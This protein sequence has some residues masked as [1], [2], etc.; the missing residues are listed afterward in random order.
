MR[1][2]KIPLGC[3][4][5]LMIV[6]TG[7]QAQPDF[8]CDDIVRSSFD[9]LRIPF[10]CGKP[11]DTV[12]LPIILDNDSTVTS[13]QFLIEFDTAWLIPVFIRDSSC[14]VADQTGCISWN[15]D[16]TYIDHVITGRM[17]ITD[18]TNGEFGLVIDTINQFTINLFQ[19][20]RNVMACNGVPEFLTLDSLPPGD[21]TIFYVKMAVKPTVPDKRLIAYDFFASNIFIVDDTVFPPDTTWFSGCNTSQMVVA[22]Y[23]GQTSTGKDSVENYQIYPNTELGYTFW[24][25][26]DVDCVP[27]PDPTVDLSANPATIQLG[28][29]SV[30]S[31]TSTNADS[32]VVR[33]VSNTRLADTDN[34]HTSGTITVAPTTAGVF[35]YTAIAYGQQDKTASDNATVT[36]SGGGGTGPVMSVN[37][38][39]SSYDQGTPISFTVTA[40][41]TTGSQI[42]VSASNLPSNAGFGNGGSVTGVSPLSGTFSW[43]PDFNQKGF[44]T[45][46]FTG[47]DAGGTTPLPVTFEVNELKFDRLF[48]TSRSGDRPV[49]GRPGKAGISFPIDLVTSQTVYGVQFDMSY[50]QNFLRVD[51]FMT[52]VRIPEYV[53]YDNI[54]VTPGAIRVVT[55]GLNNEAVIDTNTTAILQAMMTI[56]SSA[57]PWT[58]LVINLSNG[59]ESVNPDPL[60]GS[61]PLV[62]DSGVVV[63]DSLGDVNLDRYVDVA[64]V[65]NIVAYIIGAYPLV[66]RQFEVADIMENDSV[67]VFDLVADVNMIYGVSLPQ[68]APPVPGE[69]AVMSMAYND[70]S[71]GASDVLVVRSEIPREV[72]GVQLQLNY[73]PAM[74]SFGTPRLTQDDAGYAL[75]SNDNG[76]GRLKIL[77][78]KF[79]RYDSGEFMQPGEVDLVEI[80]IT[81]YKN[82]Q[83]DDKT[84]IRLTEALVSNT[85]AGA[86]SVQ[87]VDVPLP[88]KFTLS[89]NYPN[90][91]NPTTTIQFA[92]GL[93]G[94]G[95][96]QQEVDLDVFNVLGQ[97]V[98]TLFKGSYTAGEYTVNWDATDKNGRRVATG[99]YLYRLRVGDEYM[100]KKMLFLK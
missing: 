26:A 48:S 56:D 53:V 94:T 43:T 17:L 29:S 72:A 92:F 25:Q 12:L 68:P 6:T 81:A 64:D 34:G 83:S 40:T 30:L 15:V 76:Q 87:G 50:P 31:W 57:T 80:P 82:L 49:G 51:S 3:L 73:D 42:T 62:T 5:L 28:Q 86:I 20:R 9:I 14:A 75:H 71:G 44:F 61:L 97:H 69:T 90:P 59:R 22:W 11:G 33:D 47:S 88:N 23:K 84:S 35:S 27:V 4:L 79:A 37:G 19:G 65:V 21:G 2:V 24:F 78:Y 93:S 70:I 7:S 46:T 63:V 67:N 99:I 89:Q 91:F 96:T 66:E 41:N 58:D 10:H 74:I 54:G 38:L 98:T 55:F 8:G 36:V 60:V 77:L 16:S 45:I 13:F 32:V 85:V 95:A 1:L 39:Q 18:T 100:T 52:T